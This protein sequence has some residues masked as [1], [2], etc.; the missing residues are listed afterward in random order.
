MKNARIYLAFFHFIK[1]TCNYFFLIQVIIINLSFSL[2]HVDFYTY[3]Y[4]TLLLCTSSFLSLLSLF[5][6]SVV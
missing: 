2:M 6:I 5:S 3:A 4:S 1:L